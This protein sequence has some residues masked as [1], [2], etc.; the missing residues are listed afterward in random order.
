M[1]FWWA[2]QTRNYRLALA[3]GSLWTVRWVDGRLPVD[4]ARIEQLSVGD[5]VF[6]YG[7]RVSRKH[8]IGAVSRVT[9]P[10][11]PRDRPDAYSTHDP[12]QRNDG[13]Y[14]AVEV[15]A[16]GFQIP[17]ERAFELIGYEPEGPFN[18]DDRVGQRYLSALTETQAAAL[19]VEAGVEVPLPSEDPQVVH[20]GETNRWALLAHRVEQSLLRAQLLSGQPQAACALCGRYLPAS[21]LV[22]AHIRR[23][24]ELSDQERWSFDQIAFLA[25]VLGCDGLFERGYLVVREDGLVSAG[26]Q[27]GSSEV[28][29]HLASLIGRTCSAWNERTRSNF[30]AHAL[31]HAPIALGL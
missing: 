28:G 9:A 10:V 5:H 21:L 22:A 2:T 4:R 25:C 7:K 17:F 1:K 6:H 14:V 31:H 11:S 27:H 16:D 24:S 18:I 23:R 13:L 8:H 3:E 12:N 29:L 15:I 30:S 26:R 20:E 19:L